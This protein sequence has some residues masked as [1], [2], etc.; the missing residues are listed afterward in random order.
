MHTITKIF[1]YLRRINNTAH[2]E[3]MTNEAYHA[4]TQ[5][6]G[7]SGLDLIARSPAHYW[8]KY[9]DP[10][11]VREE[12]TPALLLG[13]AVHTAI[14]EPHE[15]E[16]NYFVLDDTAICIE[17]GGTAPKL[18]KRYKE[19]K[20]D[21]MAEHVGKTLLSA[22]DHVTCLRMRD[23]V[24]RHQAAKVLLQDG[25]AEQTI[26]W[27]DPQTNALCKMRPDWDSS[28]TGYVVDIKTTQDASAAG[29]G[30][31]VINYRY[32]VQSAWYM[33]GFAAVGKPK[34]GFAFI[35]VEK[36]PPYAV[37]VYYV[38]NEIYELGKRKYIKDLQTYAECLKSNSWPAYSEEFQ[39][40]QIP[41][42][43][44]K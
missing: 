18:T 11:R 31:S 4:D 28:N 30:K 2:M 34:D 39:A 32:D 12:P 44:N 36:E 1:V 7:K 10:L 23:S 26:H 8:A 24:H 19:W 22:D 21:A 42:W 43:A 15:F 37:A 17:I 14:L 25:V 13:T 33:D 9:L 20:A 41:G 40:L 29:F 6:I 27:T 3:T 35:A 38:T 16:K 5:R